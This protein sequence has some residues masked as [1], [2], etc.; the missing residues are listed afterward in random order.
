[1]KISIDYVAVKKAAETIEAQLGAEGMAKS[2]NQVMQDVQKISDAWKDE[3]HKEHAKVIESRKRELDKMVV[4][5]K[6]V[7]GILYSANK[8][9]KS[10]VEKNMK[11]A[12]NLLS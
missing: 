7:A 12:K 9:Y 1:M 2:A 3:K 8:L 11:I 5:L 10:A 6:N 4:E